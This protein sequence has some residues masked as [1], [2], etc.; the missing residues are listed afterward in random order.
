MTVADWLDVAGRLEEGR[1]AVE[2]T[3]RYVQ[4]CRAVGYEHPDL[5]SRPT[6]I[7]DWYDSEEGQ[8]LRAAGP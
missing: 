4:A 5:T 7:R 3:Q 8:D 2:H 6:Q 1:P